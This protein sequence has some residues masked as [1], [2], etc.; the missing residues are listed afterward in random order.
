MQYLTYSFLLTI[1]LKDGIYTETGFFVFA[2]VTN[3][4]AK[5]PLIG[6]K[7]IKKR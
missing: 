4:F 2:I 7:I 6:K 5:S 1:S 3:P